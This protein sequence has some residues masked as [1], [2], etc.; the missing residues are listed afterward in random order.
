MSLLRN[1]QFWQL[2]LFAGLLLSS[3]LQLKAYQLK[4]QRFLPSRYYIGEHVRM[5]LEIEVPPQEFQD[6]N[7]EG[8]QLSKGKDRNTANAVPK[9]IS[10]Q[11]K[12]PQNLNYCIHKADISIANT[13]NTYIIELVYAVFNTDVSHLA[14]FNIQGLHIPTLTIPRALSSLTED[15]SEVNGSGS[16]ANIDW[17][18][19]SLESIPLQLPWIDLS[20]ALLIQVIV[21]LPILVFQGS[22]RLRKMLYSLRQN[23]LQRKP[24]RQFLRQLHLLLQRETI[25]AQE[26]YRILSSQVRYYLDLR[27]PHPCSACTTEELAQL[28]PGQLIESQELWQGVLAILQASDDLRF[29]NISKTSSEPI[30]EQQ[31]LHE[32]SIIQNFA[33]LLE[34]QFYK[35]KQRE[36]RHL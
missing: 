29:R 31:K 20:I 1:L 10:I 21:L 14:S 18:L 19:P 27:T 33:K 32:V 2:L 25:S 28:Q 4:S 12:L 24:Y 16:N 13:P 11:H 35:K 36:L 6:D 26:Y 23:H 34:K 9:N 3:T 15:G 22:K 17:Q 30:A 7:K 5:V 8:R